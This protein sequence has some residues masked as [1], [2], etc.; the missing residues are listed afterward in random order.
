VVLWNE[1]G[2]PGDGEA[3]TQRRGDSAGVAL[4][5]PMPTKSNCTDKIF[6]WEFRFEPPD[7]CCRS[8]VKIDVEGYEPEVLKSV[9]G[10][11][12]KI[13]SIP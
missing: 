6:N 7:I 12:Q 11:R 2:E 3:W 9:L 10:S 5:A 1:R 8:C 13:L 4:V